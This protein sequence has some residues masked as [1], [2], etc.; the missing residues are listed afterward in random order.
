MKVDKFIKYLDESQD[1]N[2]T[3]S[4]KTPLRSDAFDMSD[5][6]KISLIKK[7]VA[8]ILHTLG[9]DLSDDSC[10]ESVTSESVGV[11]LT[12]LLYTSPSPRD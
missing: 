11:P 7:N 4:T 2:F 9:M 1:H 10:A 5:D 8:E 6:E 3:G 12:C